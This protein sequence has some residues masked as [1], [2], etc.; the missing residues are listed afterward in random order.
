V[1]PG[2]HYAGRGACA[3]AAS[4]LPPDA[5]SVYYVNYPSHRPRRQ[6]MNPPG[7]SDPTATVSTKDNSRTR[8]T[9]HKRCSMQPEV[10]LEGS[11][12]GFSRPRCR[13]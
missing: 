1:Q 9:D 8:L 6:H 3:S 5:H 11:G 12:A 4:F 7:L 13:R 10:S 2:A